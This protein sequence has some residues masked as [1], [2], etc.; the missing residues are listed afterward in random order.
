MR[1]SVRFRRT[2]ANYFMHKKAITMAKVIL[3]ELK[4]IVYQ[5]TVDTYYNNSI[6]DLGD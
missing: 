1:Y 2:I 5:I 6:I 4:V 3:I